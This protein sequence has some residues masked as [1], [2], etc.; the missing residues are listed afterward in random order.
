M[1]MRRRAL[2]APDADLPGPR[3]HGRGHLGVDR[4]DRSPADS[5]PGARVGAATPAGVLPKGESGVSLSSSGLTLV[6]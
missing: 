2:R 1:L 6:L 5:T 4:R 3:G